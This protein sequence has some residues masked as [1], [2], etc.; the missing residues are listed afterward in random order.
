MDFSR[1]CLGAQ[2]ATNFKIHTFLQISL[3][4]RPDGVALT[5]ERLHAVFTVRSLQFAVRTP[6]Q[7]GA[8]GSRCADICANMCPLWLVSKCSNTSSNIGVR[9]DTSSSRS[10]SHNGNWLAEL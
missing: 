3:V 2:A 8:L 5:S 9:S 6:H 10:D 7:T 1:Q 4:D